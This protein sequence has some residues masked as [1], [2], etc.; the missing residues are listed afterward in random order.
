V[1]PFTLRDPRVAATLLAS[2]V[3][4]A[5]LASLAAFSLAQLPL[6]LDCLDPALKLLP[7]HLLAL[8]QPVLLYATCLHFP[9]RE[10]LSCLAA[11]PAAFLQSLH[12]P[13][14]SPSI[15]LFCPNE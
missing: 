9:W 13:P 14:N 12:P 8:C 6:G 11:D 10:K 2:Q 15:P 7:L 3:V 5:S 4:F 1:A